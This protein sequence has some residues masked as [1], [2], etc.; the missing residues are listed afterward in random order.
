MATSRPGS[1]VI[2][3]NVQT[4]VDA[5]HHLIVAHEVTNDSSDRSQLSK[6]ALASR[7]AMG[8]PDLQ[9]LAD[10]GYYNGVELKVCQDERVAAYVPKPMTSNAKAAGRYDKTDFIYIARDD[11]YQCHRGSEQFIASPP[12]SEV[13]R[14]TSTGRVLALVVRRGISARR[15]STVASGA[16]STRM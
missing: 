15:A 3:Y 16:G 8:T 4:A 12:T 10:R 13:Y 11:E 5:K 1:A 2:G 14:S 7:E 6:M 9:V